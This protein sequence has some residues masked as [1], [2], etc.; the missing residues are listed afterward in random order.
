MLVEGPLVGLLLLAQAL[1]AALVA[2]SRGAPRTRGISAWLWLPAAAAASLVKPVVLPVAAFVLRE[3]PWREWLAAAVGGAGVCTALAAPL[4]LTHGGAPLDNLRASAERFTLKWAHF[5]SVYEPVLTAIERAT[6]AWSNDP[7]EHLARVICLG[8]LV[9]VVVAAWW[10]GRDAWTR[11]SAIFLAM[12]LLTP[13]A[14]PWYGLWALA[15]LPIVRS[16][17]VWMLSLTLP[18]GYTVLG[19]TVD[20]TVHPWVMVLAYAPV[21]AVLVADLL[22][23]RPA[24]PVPRDTLPT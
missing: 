11:S 3:R 14:H 18:W 8:M 19:D 9:A 5:G 16:R 13:A 22:A 17:A 10:R 24:D 15:L 23:P 21:Y 12:V 6:P 4:L 1:L 20:W 2:S 7:Q